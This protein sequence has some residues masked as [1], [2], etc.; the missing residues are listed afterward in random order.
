[1]LDESWADKNFSGYDTVFHVAG[2]AHSDNG[3]ISEEQKKN[4]YKINCDLA[5]ETANKAKA[6]NVKQ[7][8]FM[9]SAIVYGD[10]SPIGK[11]KVIT[12]DTQPLPANSYGDS[13]LQAEKGLLP[14]N[15]EEFKVVILRPPMV[16]GSGCKGNYSTLVKIADKVP[17]FPFVDNSRS[18]I[19][20]DNLC[21]FVRLMIDN[22][23]EGIYHPQNEFYSNTSQLIKLIAESKGK[24][25]RLIRGFT[26]ILKFLSIFTG[27]VNKAFGNLTYD[28]KI[29]EYKE[30]YRVAKDIK[31]TIN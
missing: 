20:I 11:P 22:N 2:I 5:V 26:W 7:F 24:K 13:K 12:S 15:D 10:S 4:Y 23:E 8:I 16:Y 29:S 14:L 31:D 18:M 21:E 6:Q 27:I 28:M 30:A 3:K 25:I 19:Y 9:S 1:M 17:F